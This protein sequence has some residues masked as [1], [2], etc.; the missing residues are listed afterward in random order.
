MF[1]Y[2]SIVNNVSTEN[3][4]SMIQAF[5]QCAGLP[6]PTDPCSPNT[7]NIHKNHSLKSMGTNR[8]M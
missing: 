2:N 3:I 7:N 8:P 5:C 4:P 6:N 1:V